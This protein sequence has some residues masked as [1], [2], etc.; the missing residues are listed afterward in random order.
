MFIGREA[1][2]NRLERMYSSDKLE[3]ATVYGRRRVGKTTLI[4]HFT[5]GR[6]CIFFACQKSSIADNLTELSAQISVFLGYSVT[7]PSFIEAFR[8]IVRFS[9][10]D[11]L[12]FVIDEYPYLAKKDDNAISSIIQNILDHEAKESKLFLILS[13]SSVSFM[14]DEVLGKKSPLHGRITAQFRVKPFDY[15]DSSLFVPAYSCSDKALVYG[16]TGGIPRYLELFDDSLSLK[17]NLLYNIFDSNSVLFNE[18]ENYLKEEFSEVSTYSSIL[19]AIAGG[20][21]KLAD[22]ASHAGIQ[23]GTLPAYLNK[24]K[25]VGVVDKLVP[26]GESEKK[27]VWR[28]CDLFFRFHSFFVIRNISTIVSGRMPQSYDKVVA[29]FLNDYMGKAFE[30]IAKQYIELYADLPFPLGLVGTWWGGSRT[31]HKEIEIDVVAKSAIGNDAIIGS[32]KF[33]ERKIDAQELDLMRSYSREMGG[34]GNFLYWFFSK[35]GFDDDIKRLAENDK[36]IRLYTI[37]DIYD[38]EVI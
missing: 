12:I 11:R 38:S 34:A 6:R 33:R 26:L 27:G 14:E 24:L 10:N 2:L 32:V 30:E 28:I 19:N 25:E 17:D 7:F 31:L 8:A 35:S 23:V 36:S 18:R 1:E 3:F 29:P 16:I 20:C 4:N 37:E 22:I 9:M 21:T 13:G 5:K 15:L